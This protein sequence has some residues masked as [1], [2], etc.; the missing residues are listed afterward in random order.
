MEQ[1]AVRVAGVTPTLFVVQGGVLQ[2]YI[3]SYLFNIDSRIYNEKYK[4]MRQV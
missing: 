4:R 1:T 2:G 3:C